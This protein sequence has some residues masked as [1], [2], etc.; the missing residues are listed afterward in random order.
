LDLTI[1]TTALGYWGGGA[2]AGTG[3][4]PPDSYGIDI[5]IE[6]DTTTVASGWDEYHD[7]NYT[8]NITN[9][10]DGE[11]A[12]IVV[13]GTWW[14]CS[15]SEWNA[16]LV[17]ASIDLTDFS[18]LPCRFTID[19][20]DYG[21]LAGG[22][23][24]EFWY[25]V[26]LHSCDNASDFRPLYGEVNVSTNEG[27]GDSDNLT[28]LWG[29]NRTVPDGGSDLGPPARDSDGDLLPDDVE[30]GIGTDPYNPDTDFDGFTDYEE[31]MAG[32]DPLD[33]NSHPRMGCSL[34]NPFLFIPLILWMFIVIPVIIIFLAIFVYCSP[35]EKKKQKKCCIKLLLA[36]LLLLIIGI[37]FYLFMC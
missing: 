30:R 2:I 8:V 27:S 16:T 29:R 28:I 36:L 10:G 6:S 22:A 4:L 33:Y 12:G 24:H 11:L 18:Y 13:N 3:S 37:I 5:T 17:D 23:S 15:C 7:I 19:D 21:S 32:S 34:C 35:Q 31:V 14:N 1:N 25:I 20:A 9:T 26:R